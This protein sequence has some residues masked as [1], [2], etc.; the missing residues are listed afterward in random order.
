VQGLGNVGYHAALFLSTEDG[1]KV[2]H[3]I[4]RD[5]AI[6][7]P[8]GL[9]IQ[10][11]RDWIAQQGGVIVLQSLIG[12][13]ELAGDGLIET[14]LSASNQFLT[15]KTSLHPGSVEITDDGRVIANFGI[16]IKSCLSL[17]SSGSI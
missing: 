10:A 9:D 14:E 12:A 11:L 7:D 3:V 16:G 1:C 15:E 4:E 8:N 13:D 5:G 6:S 2:T 17:L